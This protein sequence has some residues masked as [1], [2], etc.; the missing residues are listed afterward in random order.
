[1]TAHAAAAEVKLA[2]VRDELEKWREI[3]LSTEHADVV[4][5]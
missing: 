4:V 3:S 5:T 1:M 2:F